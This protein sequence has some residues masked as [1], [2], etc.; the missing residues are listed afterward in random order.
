MFLKKWF[1]VVIS[2]WAWKWFTI[3][4]YKLR[5]TLSKSILPEVGAHLKLKWE[6]PLWELLSEHVGVSYHSSDR[7]CSI[8]RRIKWLL[9]PG[10]T[11]N[12]NKASF[13][14]GFSTAGS[15]AIIFYASFCS[16]LI[17]RSF[18]NDPGN[19]SNVGSWVSVL[20]SVFKFPTLI[21]K[22]YLRILPG[23]SPDGLN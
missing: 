19:S 17:W 23:T 4:G 11:W 7:V 6:R 9:L 2:W 16:I 14:G 15:S 5:L 12:L 18:F 3:W 20:Y 21:V 8:T 22:F 10:N 1:F 13:W